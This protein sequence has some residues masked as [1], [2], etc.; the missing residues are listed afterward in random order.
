MTTLPA[1]A[2][3][4][5]PIVTPGHTITRHHAILDDHRQSGFE[6]RPARCR[7]ERMSGRVDLDPGRDL[8]FASNRN[9]IA[10]QEDAIIV[11]KRVS[12]D[13]DITP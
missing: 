4:L 9:P 6:L 2:T 3:M 13:R 5:F 12:T 11:D 10:I 7:I 8:H 1:P